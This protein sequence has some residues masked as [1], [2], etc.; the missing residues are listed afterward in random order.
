MSVRLTSELFIFFTMN[1]FKALNKINIQNCHRIRD[2]YTNFIT[3][4][5]TEQL[6]NARPPVSVKGTVQLTSFA[7]RKA[8]TS[9]YYNVLSFFMRS[10]NVTP[11]V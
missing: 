5:Y 4:G 2:F 1:C 11:T 6:N 7:S 3:A 10:L 9:F 8:T